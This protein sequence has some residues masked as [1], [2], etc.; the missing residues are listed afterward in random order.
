MTS[1]AD[2]TAAEPTHGPRRRRRAS[3]GRAPDPELAV[4]DPVLRALPGAL[5]E[6]SVEQATNSEH[7]R[8][9]WLKQQRPPHW[10]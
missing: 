1:G 8:D 5:P 2:S 4:D 9:Q 7:A 3:G 6:D 10:G